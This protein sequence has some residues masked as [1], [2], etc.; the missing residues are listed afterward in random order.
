MTDLTILSS[1]LPSYPQLV[2]SRSSIFKT[3]IPG[4]ISTRFIPGASVMELPATRRRGSDDTVSTSA[5]EVSEDGDGDHETDDTASLSSVEDIQVKTTPKG[6]MR[7]RSRT[8][9]SKFREIA[10]LGRR[11]SFENEDNNPKRNLTNAVTPRP[12]SPPASSPAHIES[13]NTLLPPTP[14]GRQVFQ[15]HRPTRSRSAP[16]GSLPKLTEDDGE[17]TPRASYT[18]NTGASASQITFEQYEAQRLPRRSRTMFTYN[19]GLSAPSRLFVSSPAWA[20]EYGVTMGGE[21]VKPPPPLHRPTTFWR[22]T[23]RSGVTSSSYSPSS[24]VI[25]RSTFVAAGL[26]FEKPMAD[27]S[28]LGV[29]SRLRNAMEEHGAAKLND[30]FWEVVAER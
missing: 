14:R 24:H 4:A 26:P 2:G 30:V 25:R 19:S 13:H 7:G 10:E 3:F 17:M 6:F 23:P 21:L 5:S 1:T 15:R 20:R 9:G 16:P 29:E 11:E 12:H 22:R 28:A 8:T 27:L 18:P